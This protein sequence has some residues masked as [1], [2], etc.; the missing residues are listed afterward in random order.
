MCVYTLRTQL[1]F[2]HIH[3]IRLSIHGVQTSTL[4]V[5]RKL[6]GGLTLDWLYTQISACHSI[7][8]TF[9]IRLASSGLYTST[10]NVHFNLSCELTLNPLYTWTSAYPPKELQPKKKR[11][12]SS[13]TLPHIPDSALKPWLVEVNTCPDLSASSPLD[14]AIKGA[15]FS[16]TFTLIGCPLVNR[17]ARV[18]TMKQHLKHEGLNLP[19]FFWVCLYAFIFWFEMLF[20]SASSQ[21]RGMCRD[22]EGAPQ[23][24]RS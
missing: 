5:Y 20:H 22:D 14:R 17:V 9:Q 6:S 2:E 24:R 15:L 3:Q 12:Y 4:S 23:T 18:A 8:Y 11:C 19:F 13:L 10:H 1:I 21:P 7:Y 16:D